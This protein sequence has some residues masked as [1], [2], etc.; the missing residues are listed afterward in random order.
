MSFNYR[1]LVSPAYLEY[2]N[3]GEMA[4]GEMDDE[5]KAC[6]Q[7]WMEYFAWRDAFIAAVKREQAK[8]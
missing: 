7:R 2:V 3:Q 8:T 1:R 6:Y 4:R 5:W